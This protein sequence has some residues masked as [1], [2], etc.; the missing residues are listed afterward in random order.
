[1]ST[2]RYT[3]PHRW[4]YL[5][6]ISVAVS[7]AAP[8]SASAQVFE[9]QT[10]GSSLQHGYG[11]ALN[12]W[13]D[14]FEGNVGVGYLDGVRF[15][16]FLKRLVG[17]DTLRLGNDAI[18]VRFVTDVFGSSHNILAQGAGIRRGTKRSQLYAFVGASA[19]AMPAPFVNALRHDR[20]VGVVQGERQLSPTLR[21]MTHALFSSR[22]TI[23]QGIEWVLPNGLELASTG[24]IGGNQ[25]Y[26][27]AS[28]ALKRET[29][30][31]RASYV[32]MG[33]RFR[34]T[35]VSTTIQSEADRENVLITFRPRPGFSFGVGRQNFRQDSTLPGV[36]DRATL[37]QVFGVA[38]LLGANM[39][40]GVFDSQ[41]PGTR[42]LSSYV[43]LSREL[44]RWLQGDAYVLQ[45]W[46]PTPARSTTP[47][48]R[49]REFITPQL[50]LLQVLTRANDRTS[51]SFGG[52]FTSGLTSLGL[53]YQV[54]HTPY[55]P[56]QPF[57]Q[58]MALTVRLP[59]G[60]YRVNA[61]SFVSPDGRVNYAGSASTFFYAGDVLTGATKPVEIRFERFIVE[62][63]V[64]DESGA[65]V[66]GA[67]VAI[68]T[69]TVFTDSRGRFF[70]R[71]PSRRAVPVR[72]A[73]EEF[74]TDGQYET[75][76]VPAS[77]TPT[78]D[79]QHVPIRVV[80]RRLP[81]ERVQTASTQTHPPPPPNK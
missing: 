56:T 37:N 25:P 36:P 30:D 34:R 60:N 62:G 57:V 53:D 27:S 32:G 14:R 77:V 17:T 21:T 59:I 10:G 44:T 19:N 61:S 22:Q 8:R 39:S 81:P 9:L 35:G 80:V 16:V 54:I 79:G 15:S 13:G 7:M 48:L 66:D 3:P 76:S 29:V 41:T 72:V 28:L 46:S 6:V 75:V 51:V 43:S 24:G 64:V 38:R 42:N 71:L 2:A 68:G 33:D 52:T 1:M 74:I 20:I 78:R 45:V 69:T 70:V 18:A 5:T 23:L 73:L 58:T 65:P 4:R 67:A 47:V 31:V 50:S 26:A 40:A 49:L 12:V 11:G 55:R 63:T